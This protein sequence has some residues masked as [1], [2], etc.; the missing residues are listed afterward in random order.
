MTKKEIHDIILVGG[1]TRIPKVR[2]LVKK[3]LPVK[4]LQLVK[5]LLLVKKNQLQLLVLEHLKQQ[6]CDV[7]RP[8]GH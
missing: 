5:K 7:E 1:S 6:F 4:K 8:E 2:Q 3:L